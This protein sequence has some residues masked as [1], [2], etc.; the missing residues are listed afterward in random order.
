MCVFRQNEPAPDVVAHA[1]F[2]SSTQEAKAGGSLWVPHTEFQ[3]GRGY[4][5]PPQKEGGRGDQ[6]ED[7]S[8]FQWHESVNLQ[9]PLL[10]NH[11][12]KKESQ[13]CRSS[14]LVSTAAQ[15]I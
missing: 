4:T 3:A 14:G 7:D 15:S 6:Y 13:G 2:N 10:Q 9:K 1:A 12:E 11:T 8:E 5:G